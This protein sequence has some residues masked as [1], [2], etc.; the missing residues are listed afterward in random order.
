MLVRLICVKLVCVRLMSVEMIRV[1]L[2]REKTN[3][4]KLQK[5]MPLPLLR[6]RT[7]LLHIV[8][9]LGELLAGGAQG[10]G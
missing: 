2:T 10:L 6:S 7:V 5:I 8:G 1:E 9:Q 3:R 4:A